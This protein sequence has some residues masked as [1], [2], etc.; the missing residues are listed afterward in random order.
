MPF[1]EWFDAYYEKI[2]K[3]AIIS[4]K[5]LSKRADDLYR[6]SNI[7]QDIWSYTKNAKIIIAD[8]STKNPNVFYELG[9]AHAISKPV[10][11]ITANMDDV[12]F[13]LRGLRIIVYDKNLPDWG[14]KL[15]TKIQKAIRETIKSPNETIPLAFLEVTNFEK[16]KISKSD[17]EFLE[18]KQDLE[19]IKK[20]IRSNENSPYGKAL[21]IE[22]LEKIQIKEK[23]EKL[24]MK[25]QSLI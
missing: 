11:L 13:D 19:L 22:D 23:A 2:Y 17:K 25:Y 1:G 4:C 14:V 20:E 8:L 16:T 3:P 7:V 10:I 21:S 24:R 15:K 12:P 18:M 6:P 9:L 5:F